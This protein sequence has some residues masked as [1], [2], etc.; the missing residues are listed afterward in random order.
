MNL[1]PTSE[2]Y[3]TAI[4]ALGHIAH[5]LPDKYP[6]ILKNIVSRKVILIIYAIFFKLN[7]ELFNQIWV[8]FMITLFCDLNLLF[9]YY[10]E[11]CESIHEHVS[12]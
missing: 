3:R 9:S 8:S 12:H 4:V 7:T 11:F 10:K 2:F 5:N 1:T 6:I